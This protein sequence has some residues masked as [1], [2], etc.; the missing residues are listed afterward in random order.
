MIMIM[1]L[2]PACRAQAPRFRVK[3]SV[4]LTLLTRRSCA[5]TE[6]ACSVVEQSR[7]VQLR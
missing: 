1:I 7:G 2:F 6:E 4:R 5:L 3:E